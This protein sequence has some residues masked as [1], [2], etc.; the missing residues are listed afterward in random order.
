M[1][2]PARAQAFAAAR[3]AGL[4]ARDAAWLRGQATGPVRCLGLLARYRTAS[5][6]LGG[7]S[8]RLAALAGRGDDR[9]AFAADRRVYPAIRAWGPAARPLV[10]GCGLL[11]G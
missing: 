4:A 10:A 7:V 8:A 3:A 9:A 11:T 2:S 5:A 6:R 1:R